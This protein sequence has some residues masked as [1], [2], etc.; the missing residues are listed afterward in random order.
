MV[1]LD[2][3]DFIADFMT[4]L[5]TERDIDRDMDREAERDLETDDFSDFFLDFDR[6]DFF[7]FFDFC[8]FSLFLGRSTDSSLFLLFFLGLSSLILSWLVKFKLSFSLNV[9]D[10]CFSS[11]PLIL[12]SNG[13][14]GLI[15]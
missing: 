6:F 5:E 12:E 10:C 2:S 7:D 14:I 15:F 11:S 8:D 4:D 1:D 13:P 9:K 3:T